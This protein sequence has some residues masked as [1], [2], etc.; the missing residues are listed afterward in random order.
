[1]KFKCLLETN[2]EMRDQIFE[3]LGSSFYPRWK[4]THQVGILFLSLFL[5]HYPDILS[6][7]NVDDV[8]EEQEEEEEDRADSDEERQKKKKRKKR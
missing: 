6:F 7:S 5:P 8:E 2:N 3:L 1:V 4:E